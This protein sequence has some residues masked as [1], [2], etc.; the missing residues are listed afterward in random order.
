MFEKGWVREVVVV[1]VCVI[2]ETLFG[3]DFIFVLSLEFEA[4]GEFD[5]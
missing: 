1:V 5:F 4:D 2:H 3:V